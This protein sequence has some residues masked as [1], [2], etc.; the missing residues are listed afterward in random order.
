MWALL[1][2]LACNNEPGGG[3]RS[4]PTVDGVPVDSGA[5]DSG[6][7]ST[8]AGCEPT[9]IA[10]VGAGAAGLTA[11]RILVDDGRDVVVLEARDRIGG[12]THTADVGAARVD[13]GGAWLHGVVGHPM[14]DFGAASGL[15]WR[16]SD[17]PWSHVYDAGSGR[18]GDLWGSLVGGAQGFYVD[19]PRLRAQ[20]PDGSVA[21]GRE[22]WL[23]ERGLTGDGRRLAAFGID[24]YIVELQYGSSVERQSLEYVFAEPGILGGGDQIPDG[25]YAPFLA[26]LATGVDVRLEQPVTAIAHGPDGARVLT[27]T[28]L[29][30][31]AEQVLVAVPLAVLRADRITFDPPLADERRAAMDRLDVGALEKVVLVF[32]ERWFAGG[33][34]HVAADGSGRFPEFYDFTDY[35]GAPT[36]VGLYGGRFSDE[37]D[38]WTDAEVVDGALAVLAEA[39][40]GP[41]PAPVATAVTRWGEDP[42]ALGSYLYLPVG[43]S[44]ADIAALAAPEGDRLG[45]AGEAT[46]SEHFATVHGAMLSGIREARRLG[47][48]TI[49]T[50]GLE[51]Y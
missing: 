5:E 47:V 15:G 22:R 50:P 1:A 25:G 16:A 9:E 40:G 23:D 4:D 10:V 18:R 30:V 20:L 33:I 11:A 42:Y 7:P 12:R 39:T 41:V 32:D 29:E 2:L 36:L 34:T 43:A 21:D 28:G 19:L 14:A 6:S 44:P 26:A 35:A 17:P 48:V 8:P 49:Q 13:L 45:F 46:H 38:G 27:A 3:D 51:G 24:Q 37:V 31:C